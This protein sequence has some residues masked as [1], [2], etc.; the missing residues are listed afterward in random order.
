MPRTRLKT[1]PNTTSQS[2]GCTARAS[3]SVGSRITFSSSTWAMAAL[4]LK[5]SRN[6]D[7]SAEAISCASG[8]AD[9]T[10]ISFLLY[11]APAVMREDIVERGPRAQATLELRRLSYCGDLAQMQDGQRIAQR[12]RLFHGMGRDQDRHL[13]IAA[14]FEEAFPHRL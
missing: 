10:I 5:K 11:G 13:I 2:T 8:L 9:V 4:S 12:V 7:D 14:Q 6:A 1:S 3:T